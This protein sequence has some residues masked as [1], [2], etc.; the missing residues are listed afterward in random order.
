MER[1]PLACRHGQQGRVAHSCTT[2]RRMTP[3]QHHDHSK[4]DRLL[5]K[6][7]SQTALTCPTPH[8]TP[9]TPPTPPIPSLLKYRKQPHPNNAYTPTARHYLPLLPPRSHQTPT[10]CHPSPHVC[11]P[12]TSSSYF[13][14]A[15][16]AGNP[17][18]L[19][20]HH[21]SPS[22]SSIPP[23]TPPLPH[24]PHS[25]ACSAAHKSASLAR[26]SAG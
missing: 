3:P 11:H 25:P 16:P 9:P 1:S 5:K 21:S 19:P 26:T 15:L 17:H 23:P 12:A 18:P 13:P 10:P 20:P 2:E 22:L 6:S 4:R 8:P 14:P 7:D 24:R